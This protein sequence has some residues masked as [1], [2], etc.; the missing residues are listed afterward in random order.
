MPI[1]PFIGVKILINDFEDSGV[2]LKVQEKCGEL[3][4]CESQSAFVSRHE[5][6]GRWRSLRELQST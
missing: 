3:R 1:Y 5:S 6:V 2:L 4:I